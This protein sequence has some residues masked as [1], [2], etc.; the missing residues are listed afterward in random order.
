[1][2]T[3]TIGIDPSTMTTTQ[4]N[5]TTTQPTTTTTTQPTTTTTTPQPTTITTTEPKTT[6][7]PIEIG[8]NCSSSES[9]EA[10]NPNTECN[11]NGYCQC[12]ADDF[13]PFNGTCVEFT[14]LI[15]HSFSLNPTET[16]I[17]V[18]WVG[19]TGLSSE[20]K[21]EYNVTV[22]GNN[23]DQTNT[24]T[25]QKITV[26]GL[27][28]GQIYIVYVFTVLNDSIPSE[29]VDK[30]IVTIP[31]PP[32]CPLY[33]NDYNAPN[34]TI[35]WNKPDGEVE[36]YTVQFDSGTPFNMTSAKAEIGNLD[37]G[38]NYTLTLKTYAN[39]RIS[40]NGTCVIRTESEVPD[41]PN[42]VTKID[43]EGQDN[44]NI[45]ITKTDEPRGDIVGYRIDI[46]GK[47]YMDESFDY[48]RSVIIPDTLDNI[49]QVT[50]LQAGTFY[51]IQVYTIND[52]FNSSISFNFTGLRTAEDVPESIFSFNRIS[53][54]D[55]FEVMFQRPNIPNGDITGYKILVTGGRPVI[56][57]EYHLQNVNISANKNCTE[58]LVSQIEL[59]QKNME[60]NVTDLLPSVTF[61]VNIL[62]YTA[63][64]PGIPFTTT[65]MT[66]VTAPYRPGTVYATRSGQSI[67]VTWKQPL[68]KTGPTSYH[69]TALDLIEPG[70][71]V[72]SYCTTNKFD[73]TNCT[74]GNLEEFWKYKFQVTAKV[75]EWK[76][77]S[78]YSNII[79]TVPGSKCIFIFFL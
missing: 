39:N 41:P 23:F 72:L 15:P 75:F 56:C 42:N 66:N 65:V 33:R 8:G 45:S 6:P 54:K 47:N 9:C 11:I 12:K 76:N 20:Y 4:P 28:A 40:V 22:K 37:P 77:T 1:M 13:F 27:T 19:P 26:S 46:Y 36:G 59:N 74:G 67:L 32:D 51:Y 44:F 30:S 79:T 53:S 17:T 55:S 58:V 50:G 5:T 68:L 71:P 38:K 16:T 2:T 29:T 10:S 18:A 62:A 31:N 61:T 25:E 49:Y 78:D 48:R 57:K 73:D 69:V 21:V 24:T 63:E 43:T 70:R 14:S 64:G 60:L 52:K 7:V 3:P 34:I 35:T